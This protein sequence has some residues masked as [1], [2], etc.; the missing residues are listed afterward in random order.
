MPQ[1]YRHRNA[2]HQQSAGRLY[3][4]PQNSQ[5][6]LSDSQPG[7]RSPQPHKVKDTSLIKTP[8]P[9]TTTGIKESAVISALASS[10]S[11]PGSNYTKTKAKQFLEKLQDA[12]IPSWR[13]GPPEPVLIIVPTQHESNLTFPTLVF[14][15]KGYSTG[16]QVFEAQNQA[17]VSGA[18]GV[19][20]QMML[21][22]LV[23]RATGS[24]DVPLTPSKNQPLLVFAICPEGPYHELWAQYTVIEDDEHRF[25]MALLNTCHGVMPKEVESFFVQVNNVLNWTAGPFL[26]SVVDGLGKVVRKSR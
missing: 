12:T 17:A 11:S 9:N 7:N 2:C 20:I 6:P 23:K 3:I 25:S 13:D 15:G 26:K 18:S 4:S 14:E 21:D 8:R 5:I 1:L 10:L 22:E 24:S 19:K 16:K